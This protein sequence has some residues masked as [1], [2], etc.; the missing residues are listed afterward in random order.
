[1][2]L[3]YSQMKTYKRPYFIQTTSSTLLIIFWS[4]S[5]YS[6]RG[7]YLSAPLTLYI[8]VDKVV[9]QIS[10]IMFFLWGWGGLVS[11]NGQTCSLWVTFLFFWRTTVLIFLL[12][13]FD[14]NL[15]FCL[16]S[17]NL[18]QKMYRRKELNVYKDILYMKLIFL[19]RWSFTINKCSNTDIHKDGDNFHRWIL[20]RHLLIQLVQKQ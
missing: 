11:L 6:S 4:C 7:L 16:C 14:K 2:P 19:G 5:T 17:Q 12:S 13:D 15:P 9:E 10:E 8:W 1:M 18:T 20:S 3:D